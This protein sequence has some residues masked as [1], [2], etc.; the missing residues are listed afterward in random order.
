MSPLR[1]NVIG[2]GRRLPSI[3]Y[4]LLLVFVLFSIFT[5]DF[6]SGGNFVNVIRQGAVLI[7]VSLGMVVVIMGGGIDLSVGAILGL[8]GTVLAVMLRGNAG[9]WMAI[10]ISLLACVAC[11][12]S[13]GL[14]ITKGKIFPFIVTFGMLFMV[15][16]ISL[17]ITQGGSVHIPNESFVM[18][19]QTNYFG[20]PA[21]LWIIIILIFAVS[22][23]VRRTRFG[24]HMYAIGVS[25][26]NA[27]ALGIRV[28][29]LT[30]ASYTLCALLAGV[31]GIILASRVAT[32][33][34]LVGV[35]VE[36]EA[37][38][39]VAI[40]GTPIGGGHGS[41][42]G[43]IFGAL[44]ITLLNNGLTLAGL[45][46]EIVAVIIGASVMAAVVGAQLLYHGG[47]RELRS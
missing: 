16:S 37:I 21:A 38:A 41:I 28:D 9:L 1:G 27:R 40:G 23:L 32:G 31:A 12:L 20:A 24:S 26:E 35:G 11:G 13:S 6:F 46:S 17:G 45:R 33:N 44:F 30:I 3:A 42:A 5:P 39:S 15:R 2:I 29:L 7:I 18:F 19:G 10:S 25:S 8:S 4:V 34:A 43:T 47:S 36:F 22:V 14:I